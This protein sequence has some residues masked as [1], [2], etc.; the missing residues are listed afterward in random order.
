MKTRRELRVACFTYIPQE[1][2]RQDLVGK[3]TPIVEKGKRRNVRRR[4][5]SKSHALDQETKPTRENLQVSSEWQDALFTQV[6]I[7]QYNTHLMVQ[8][9][10]YAH[11][12]FGCFENNI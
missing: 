4:K 3:T 12:F 8:H 10:R 7:L 6:Q 1:N 5:M 9:M 11:S 2:R